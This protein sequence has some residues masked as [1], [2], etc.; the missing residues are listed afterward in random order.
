[1]KVVYLITGSG[2]S[3][4]CGNCYRDMLYLRAIRKVP[5]ISAKAIPLYLPPDRTTYESGFEK[6]VFFGAISMFLREKVR[7]FRNMPVFLEKI[8]DAAPFLKLAARQAG[9]TRTEGFENLTL[10]MI[11]GDNAFRKNEME[12][13]VRYL[14]KDG[15]PDIIHLSNAL[16]LGIARQLKN[17]IK[18]KIVCSLLNE[19]DWIDDMVEPYRGKAWEM[20]AQESVYVDSF[21]TPSHYYKELFKQKTGLKGDN[22]F[23]VPLGF[24]PDP[25]DIPRNENHPPAVGYFCRVN[26]HN[27]FDKLVDAFIK[28][29][30]DSIVSD[31]TL[32][33]CGGF[34]GDD[35]PFIAEQIKKVREHGFQKSVRIYPEFQGNKK[36][37]FFS[38]VD[39]ISVPVRKYDGYG[40][41]ILEANS[42]GV[43]VVQPATGAFPEILQIT[44]GGV[45]YTPDTVEE[46]CEVLLRLLKDR[47]L[48]EVLGSNGKM[49]VRQELSLDKMSAGLSEVYSSNDH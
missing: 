26:Y 42:S 39:V 7:I 4:Y 10:S 21:V 3:F 49:N 19:D 32:N 40:L 33:V 23:V 12:R 20:I 46:L 8:F 28:L 43:P 15:K 31:L 2:G 48:R 17:R 30:S 34:T 35:K 25:V 44:K 45:T 13:L 41:Y 9:T 14:Q 6:E 47:S 29:K 18:V 5:G 24:D 38:E 22:I 1:M 27:G 37:E 11:E 36:L 16:I